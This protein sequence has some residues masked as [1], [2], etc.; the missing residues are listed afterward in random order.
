MAEAMRAVAAREFGWVALA[1]TQSRPRPRLTADAVLA[2]L[3]TAGFTADPV[4]E[5]EFEQ[6][7]EEQRAWLS[8]PIFTERA[9]PGLDYEQRMAVLARAYSVPE[10]VSQWTVFTATA[11]TP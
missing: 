11:R 2:A 4:T 1:S 5:L 8:I 9:L 7:L 6:D 10:V 3:A